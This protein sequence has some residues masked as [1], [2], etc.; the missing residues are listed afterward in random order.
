AVPWFVA[1]PRRQIE[2]GLQSFRAARVDEFAHD[3][4]PAAAKRRA[5]DGMVRC[6]C[7]PQAEAVV[8]FRREA[9]PAGTAGLRSPPPLPR[10]QLFGSEDRGRFLAVAPL[11]IGEGVDAEVQEQ[12]ELVTLPGEL[13]W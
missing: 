2:A 13:R 6:L 10:V 7:R 12:R 1:I 9:H 5:R 4:A 3:V 8:M 11:A